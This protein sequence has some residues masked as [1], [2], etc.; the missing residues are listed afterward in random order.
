MLF[1]VFLIFMWFAANVH[2]PLLPFSVFPSFEILDHIYALSSRT[3]AKAKKRRNENDFFP[4][5]LGLSLSN[6][7]IMTDHSVLKRK[8]EFNTFWH[9]HDTM[10]LHSPACRPLN[11]LQLHSDIFFFMNEIHAFSARTHSF[12]QNVW[13]MKIII[14]RWCYS[15]EPDASAKQRQGIGFGLQWAENAIAV[16]C[17][18]CD[19]IFV[20]HAL[21]RRI[22]EGTRLVFIWW[23]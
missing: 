23:R 1:G 9:A 22:S 18:S 4:I 3:R 12:A 7:R 14:M 5:Q 20:S 6:N 15:L 19:W 10:H 2:R 13:W 16:R 21:L 8:I 17:I 11:R